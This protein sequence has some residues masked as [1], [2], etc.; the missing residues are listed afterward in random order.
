M[1]TT[2]GR[3]GLDTTG[4]L[5]LERIEYN[6]LVYTLL[7]YETNDLEQDSYVELTQIA[8]YNDNY[9]IYISNKQGSRQQLTS[10]FRSICKIIRQLSQVVRFIRGYPLLE[11]SSTNKESKEEESEVEELFVRYYTESLPQLEKSSKEERE[12]SKIESIIE[13]IEVKEFSRTF[14][15]N[16]LILYLLN[17]VA[18]SRLLLLLQDSEGRIQIVDKSKLQ[19]LFT[20]I[21]RVLQDVPY[22]KGSIDYIRIV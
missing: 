16:D 10:K 3:G 7:E 17:T 9:A 22:I 1:Y 2:K 6:T 20:R 8:Y 11:D 12:A 18:D 13:T 4:I 19:E 21:R 15:S 5:E 14:Y